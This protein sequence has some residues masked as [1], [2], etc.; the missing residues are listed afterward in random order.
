MSWRWLTHNLAWKLGALIL[1][2]LL[3][4]TTA[5][6]PTLVTTHAVPILYKDLAPDLLI[7]SDAVDMVR[8]EL[9]GP[10]NKL[11][12]A[13][14]GDMTILLDLA[15]V[16]GPG[17]RTFTLSGSDVHLPEGVTFLRAVPS[18][19]RLAFGR[20]MSKEVSVEIQIG[21]PPPPGYL[22]VRQTVTPDRIGIT[23]PEQRLAAISSA[24]TDAIDLSGATTPT[25]IRTSISLADSLVSLEASP[26]VTV[27]FD[28]EKSGQAHN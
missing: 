1:A 6:E 17:Q 16:R 19:L 2:I 11:S 3:W 24:R 28:I 15:S 7:G 26:V 4:L 5:D 22:V 18:Q 21:A 14:L 8:V 20:R 9:R 23:G 25:E 10:A 13:S 12:P 27:R